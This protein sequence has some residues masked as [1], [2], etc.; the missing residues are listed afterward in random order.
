M[1]KFI[2]LIYWHDIE[3]FLSKDC[4]KSL[5]SFIYFNQLKQNSKWIIRF[6]YEIKDGLYPF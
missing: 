5:I 4:I 1:V 2:T 3:K 6:R